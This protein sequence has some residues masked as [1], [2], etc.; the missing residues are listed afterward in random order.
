MRE[1]SRNRPTTETTLIVSLTPGTPGRRQQ[2]PRTLM[3]IGSP[4]W[5]AR[6]SA[7]MQR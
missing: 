5:E 3:S 1:C 2:I 4:A 7:S 6:Y